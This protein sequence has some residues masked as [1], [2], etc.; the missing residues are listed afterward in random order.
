MLSNISM[1]VGPT[2]T[3]LAVQYLGGYSSAFIIVACLSM[4]SIAVVWVFVRWPV[5][6]VPTAQ[7]VSAV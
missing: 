2:I 5:P 4:V 6:P 3:G 7:P 1:M